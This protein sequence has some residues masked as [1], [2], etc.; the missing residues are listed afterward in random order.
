MSVE[1]YESLTG[2]E[3]AGILMLAL[4]DE[5]AGR[6]FEHL[7]SEEVMEISQTMSLLGR[8]DAEIVERLLRERG[9]WEA[10]IQDF[11]SGRPEAQSI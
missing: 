1:R 4:G 6:L 8:V 9:D 10:L 5:H 11:I 2:A 3:K 7:D